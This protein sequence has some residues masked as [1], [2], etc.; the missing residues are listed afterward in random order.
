[1]AT[2]LDETINLLKKKEQ[3]NPTEKIYVDVLKEL[4]QLLDYFKLASKFLEL[5]NT[6]T[7]YLLGLLPA[8]LKIHL[9]PR[10]EHFHPFL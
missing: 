5:F 4:I 9:Q 6:P 2:E 10:D 1:M 3:K 8:K 7:L